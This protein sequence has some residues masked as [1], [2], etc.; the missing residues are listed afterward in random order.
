MKEAKNNQANL[1]VGWID[2]RK[3]YDMV[4]HVWI[5]KCLRMVA[6]PSLVR[7][8]IDMVMG[9]WASWL[10]VRKRG[11]GTERFL[12]QFKR[13]LYQ[14]DSMSPL[15]FVLSVAPLSLALGALAGVQPSFLPSPVTHIL[16]MDDLKLYGQSP[17]ELGK[18]VEIVEEVAG[19]VGMSLGLRKCAVA[20]MRGGKLQKGGRR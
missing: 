20:H 9:K 18:A 13:G 11:G 19:A 15:L 10:E 16:F 8:G 12:V 1:S 5:R 2:F 6:A 4:P 14:G 7:N 17:E 3:A